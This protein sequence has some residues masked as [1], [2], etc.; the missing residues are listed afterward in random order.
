VGTLTHPTCLLV[1]D[2]YGENLLRALQIPQSTKNSIVDELPRVA[3]YFAFTSIQSSSD[4]TVNRRTFPLDLPVYGHQDALVGQGSQL[5]IKSKQRLYFDTDLGGKGF[6]TSYLSLE[7]TKTWISENHHAPLKNNQTAI[8]IIEAI[9]AQQAAIPTQTVTSHTSYKCKTG[10]DYPTFEADYSGVTQ[11][12]P[13]R[14]GSNY[15]VTGFKSSGPL[16]IVIHNTGNES[17]TVIQGNINRFQNPATPVSAHYIVGLNENGGVEIIQMVDEIYMAYH[18]GDVIMLGENVIDNTN[19]IGIEV[20]GIGYLNGWPD[21]KVYSAVAE[22]VKDIAR[23]A[24][25]NGRQI[26]LDRNHIVG[27]E[28]ISLSGKWDPGQYWNWQYFMESQLG[29]GYEP[30]AILK[31]ERDS[32]TNQINL[33]MM[34]RFN[35]R[36]SYQIEVSQDEEPYKNLDTLHPNPIKNSVDKKLGNPSNFKLAS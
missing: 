5:W 12:C 9:G 6:P 32:Q 33:S 29:T 34:A 15:S 31:A 36:D 7:D 1:K 17:A 24:K 20:V 11:V 10:P 30:A 27:H 25:E 13:A 3:D 18:A 26:E 28:E 23:R 14:K 19:S 8:W 22:L 16:Y 35:G 21:E 2:Q 4:Y